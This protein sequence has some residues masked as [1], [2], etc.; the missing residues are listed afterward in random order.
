METLK[1]AFCRK[2][3]C[4]PEEFERRALIVAL[5]PHARIFSSFGGHRDDRF[6][7]DRAV[8]DFRS[9]RRSNPARTEAYLQRQRH[10]HRIHRAGR[11]TGSAPRKTEEVIFPPKKSSEYYSDF[12]RF[13]FAGI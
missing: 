6:V 2:F 13:R 11:S 9:N 1:D 7:V 5:Y 4:A 10:Q 12:R 3:S 8:V